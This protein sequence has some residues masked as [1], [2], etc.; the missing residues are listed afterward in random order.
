MLK[1]QLTGDSAGF[2]SAAHAPGPGHLDDQLA[3]LQEGARNTLRRGEL[4]LETPHDY[5]VGGMVATIGLSGGDI[6][7]MVKRANKQLRH[8]NLMQVVKHNAPK[9]KVVAGPLEG[10]E[11]LSKYVRDKKGQ[12]TSP[13]S[14]YWFHH[15]LA[16]ELPGKR[17]GLYLAG[18]DVFT[19]P[20]PMLTHASYVTG[21][22]L[23]PAQLVKDMADGVW[24]PVYFYTFRGPS[25]HGA[26]HRNGY[27]DL[28]VLNAEVRNWLRDSTKVAT[29]LTN[30]VVSMA[31]T[32]A[33]LMQAINGEV[34]Q[35]KQP[36]TAQAAPSPQVSRSGI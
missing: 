9:V 3:K 1:I 13:I 23:R 24:Q 33:W 12:I 21:Q 26:M 36:V 6:N 2:N 28:I 30:D 5:N 32:Y 18:N 31:G 14:P 34:Q 10:L 19:P 29:H 22:V 20:S 15:S 25:V 35:G 17:Y 7:S 16:M 27:Y 11:L 8:D 4:M